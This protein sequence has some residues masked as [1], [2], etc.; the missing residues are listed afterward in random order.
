MT[1]SEDTCTFCG[2]LNKDSILFTSEFD[3]SVGICN[4][5]ASECSD[6]FKDAQNES[7]KED[8]ENLQVFIQNLKILTPKNIKKHLD[9]YIIGQDSAKVVLSTCIYNHYKRIKNEYLNKDDPNKIEIE[10][11]NILML[12][13]TGTGKTKILKLISKLLDIPISISD[14]TSITESGYSGNDVESILLP[15][16]SSEDLR[17]NRTGKGEIGIV[18]IDEIDKIR[19]TS[20]NISISR[21]VSGQGVQQSLLKM[22]EGSTVS[23]PIDGGRKHPDDSMISMKTDNILFIV[24]GAFDGIEKIVEKRNNINKIGFSN[25]PE[26]HKKDIVEFNHWEHIKNEDIIEFGMIKEFIGR[27]SNIV[28]FNKLTKDNL[29]NI[30]KFAK[31]SVLLQFQ[32]M[33]KIDGIEL[34]FEEDAIIAIAEKALKMQTGARAIR[35]VIEKTLQK[36]MFE[37]PESGITKIIVT[38][39]SV[40]D[41]IDPIC[42]YTSPST[43]EEASI[44]ETDKVCNIKFAI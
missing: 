24:G 39:K 31:N 34:E 17:N 29:I 30:T 14:A 25:N 12:G 32:Y 22:I 16:I 11:S 36:V 40:E 38:K 15:L 21:D 5:C 6:C 28:S 1:N 10:K 37:A 8:N 41:E 9:Q 3:E 33:L 20:R 42:I 44:S 2:K 27:F 13:P 35:N 18:Y 7:T 19:S 43:C 4:I 23:L 26:K